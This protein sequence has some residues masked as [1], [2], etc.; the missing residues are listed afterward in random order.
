[1][2]I[3]KGMKD[4]AGRYSHIYNDFKISRKKKKQHRHKNLNNDDQIYSNKNRN[5]NFQ[6]NSLLDKNQTK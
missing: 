3:I 6:N 4:L 1:M 5:P 2:R